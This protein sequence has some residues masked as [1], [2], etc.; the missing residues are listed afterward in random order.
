MVEQHV[1][2]DRLFITCYNEGI[3]TWNFDKPE[4]K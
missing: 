2:L 4:M 3:E 1:Y